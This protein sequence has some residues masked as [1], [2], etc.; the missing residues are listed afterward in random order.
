MLP[1]LCTASHRLAH[2]HVALQIRHDL[3]PRL[4]HLGEDAALLL[5]D[6]LDDLLRF[7]DRSGSDAG[8]RRGDVRDARPQHVC[9]EADED[10]PQHLLVALVHVLVVLLTAGAVPLEH[11]DR[12]VGLRLR[13]ADQRH[14][15]VFLLRLVEIFDAPVAVEGEELGAAP[16]SK[17][18][19][20]PVSVCTAFGATMT[21]MDDRDAKMG[22]V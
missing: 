5:L 6:A 21:K 22:K 1:P 20:A 4:E 19:S 12:V 16:V 11:E 17:S 2:S 9:L 18:Q 14:P 15:D 10:V 3:E 7:A 8:L 13:D